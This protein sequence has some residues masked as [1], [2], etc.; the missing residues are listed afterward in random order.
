MW[1]NC[2]NNL[3]AFPIITT[4]KSSVKQGTDNQ[5]VAK[6]DNTSAAKNPKTGDNNAALLFVTI[7]LISATTIISARK[8]KNV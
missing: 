2:S 5:S 8:K 3:L 1:K 4:T 7:M 6:A